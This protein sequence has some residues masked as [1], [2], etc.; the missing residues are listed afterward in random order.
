MSRRIKDVEAIVFDLDGTLISYPIGPFGIDERRRIQELT[1]LLKDRIGKGGVMTYW[2]VR[3]KLKDLKDMGVLRLVQRGNTD[4]L[5]ALSYLESSDLR[6]DVKKY[7]D[8][9]RQTLLDAYLS[10]VTLY[11]DVVACLSALQSDDFRLGLLSNTPAFICE[12]ALD[13]FEL[14]EFFDIVSSTWT[15][16]SFKPDPEIFFYMSQKLDVGPERTLFVGDSLDC[17]V[18][19]AKNIGA[20]SAYLIREHNSPGNEEDLSPRPDLVLRDLDELHPIV[21]KVTLR[22]QLRR[23]LKPILTAFSDTS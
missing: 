1:I 8:V 12:A 10:R 20:F 16:K 6:A 19:G 4:F 13:R 2:R 15:L 3:S 17:D 23:I 5:E 14:R 7:G 21:R 18:Q 9:F 11:P 22:A